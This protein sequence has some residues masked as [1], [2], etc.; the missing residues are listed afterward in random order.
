M[1]LYAIWWP[2]GALVIFGANLFI[3]LFSADIRDALS[4][5]HGEFGTYYAMAT[6]A[7][8]FTLFMAWQ[9]GGHCPFEKTV[10]HHTDL[11][12]LICHPF[13]LRTI[14][15]HANHR[16]LFVA[17]L[18]ARHDVTCL[19][20]SYGK[21]VCESKRRT[22]AFASFGMTIAES[23]WPA[24]VVGML[25]VM[26]WRLVWII[27]PLI[28]FVSLAPFINQLTKRS[29]L[30][31]GA[32][33]EGLSSQNKDKPSSDF[34]RQ[35]M[36]K[37][38]A[39]W[40]AIIWLFVPSFTVTGLLFHQI[41][42]A[43]LKS[44]DLLTWAAHYSFYALAAI[45]GSA[46]SGILVDRFTAH[47]IIW[48]TQV[49]IIFFAYLLWLADGPIILALFFMCFWALFRHAR[50]SA[51]FII[52]REMGTSHLGAIKAVTLPINVMASAGAPI[53]MGIMIDKG[54][55]LTALM[56]LLALVGYFP[57]SAPFVPLIWG[58]PH[59]QR[60]ARAPDHKISSQGNH[61]HRE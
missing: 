41:Y 1:A 44:I 43:E 27:I 34:T 46:L 47:A 56:I 32:G 30:Q 18:G 59:V 50:N 19:V 12:L 20:D 2:D 52:G 25:A 58:C 31:D 14:S 15:N 60:A 37:D 3:S 23:L 21:T 36:F 39:F 40:L 28:A 51:F 38:S 7:S 4:L 16:H 10:I 54:A 9:N 26:N 33:F 57:Q 42:I 6:A 53:I 5:S 49:P 35:D 22:L 17:S 24:L 8:A 29:A 48:A 45:L 11:Y 61:R 13:C 55:S